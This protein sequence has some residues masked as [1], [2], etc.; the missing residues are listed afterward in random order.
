M[1]ALLE[2]IGTVVWTQGK[3]KLYLVEWNIVKPL[4]HKWS[5]NRDPDMT[6]VQEIVTHLEN[7]GYVPPILHV[8]DAEE[9]LVCYDGNHRREAFN[10]M[11]NPPTVILD[12]LC[13]ASKKEIY[14]DFTN[15]NKS[16]QVPAMFVGDDGDNVEVLKVRDQIVKLVRK[17]ET[18]YKSFA[19]T[20]ARCHAPNFNRDMLMENILDIWKD[21]DGMVSIDEIEILLDK[22]NTMYAEGKLCRSH[23]TFRQHVLQKCTE[24]GLWLF[25]DRKVPSDHV[26]M[27]YNPFI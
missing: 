14:N 15:L 21:M 20:S 11:R 5:C 8:A 9:G 12:V 13:N 7:G 19:S 16:V 10:L 1:Q 3:H 6:R 18:K 22:L 17:Y 24:G 25:I 23:A 4:I 26:K 27:L 2:R